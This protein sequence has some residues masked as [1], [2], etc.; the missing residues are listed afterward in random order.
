M[1]PVKVPNYNKWNRPP[2]AIYEDNY[3]YG[4]NFYQPMIDY[5]SAKGEGV[6]AEPPHLPWNNERGLDKYRFDKPIRTYSDED[7]T[8]LSHQIAD[9][10][11]RDLNTFNVTKRSPFS[12][13]ATADAANV[14]KHVSAESLVSKTKKKKEERE[15]YKLE[16]QKKRRNEI[17]K[18]LEL[19]E[20][21][22]NV[23][24]ELRGKA[25]MYRGKSAKAIAQTLLEESRR[26]VA[27]SRTK[28]PEIRQQ[29]RQPTRFEYRGKRSAID[30]NLSQITENV[31]SKAVAASSISGSAANHISEKMTETIHRAI[32]ET[33]P[34]TCVVRIKEVPAEYKIDESY[35]HHLSELKKTIKQFDELSDC[36]L[37]DSSK[38]T[39]I[40]IEQLNARVVEAETKLKSEVTRIKK[41]LQIQITELEL[42]LDVAN[43]TN[44]DLQKVVKKQSL[45]L[46]EIQ[47]HYDEVQRQLQVTL[48]QYGVAQRRIQSLT[49]EVEEI[50]GNYEQALRAKRTVEQSYEEAV[51]RINEL[52]VINVNL[53]SSKAKI[54]QELAAVAADYD[55]ITK[56]L[57]IADE[58]YQ[59]V[60]TE[61]KHTVEHLHE[62]QERIVKI[63][64]VKKSLEIE[65]KNISVRLEE[66]EANAIV[67]G[68]RIISKLEA[69]IKD[70]ELEM[71][72]EKRRH[73]ETIK[74]LR[75]KERQLKEVMIQCEEDQKNIVLLQD[76]LE[77]TT[78]K[79]NIYK[80]QLTEQE[81]MSQQNVTRV[82]RFQRE[83]E[84]AE[85]RAD[86]AESNLSLIRAKHRTF[87][88][89]STV[90]GSQVY[91]VQESRAISSERM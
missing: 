81:G 32:R 80:R 76:S 65:V 28:V 91:L 40:E 67:G 2:T 82:R 69:R 54:E 57:R 34:S 4:I 66:V 70:M 7:V 72:E 78:Q 85:D 16:R 46:T 86:C 68:K 43:K 5:I 39:S 63:E 11:K 48:D 14:E 60:Q 87:V 18:E 21:E 44:I 6:A 55:E 90:P 52:T 31:L 42:S 89:T 71:D 26:N 64:A 51:T 74:I 38:Q 61:L 37:I 84:A 29:I 83:L 10:A 41:K 88:T 24:A 47:T 22:V 75:K 79:V 56:E 45:Q 9:Q 17:E 19:Y 20:K 1:P 59:R 50:R 49:G 36:L 33:S 3:G 30:K 25:K 15:K 53:S 27:E 62:E 77:K 8:R 35:L 13:I 73:A 12:V 23:G 58:R